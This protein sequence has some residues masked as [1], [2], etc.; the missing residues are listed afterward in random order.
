MSFSTRL[1]RGPPSV[2]PCKRGRFSDFRPLLRVFGT[3]ENRIGPGEI[4]RIKPWPRSA[5][6][7]LSDVQVPPD[8][9]RAAP[10]RQVFNEA[11]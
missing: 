5:A 8:P 2:P 1:F 9:T 10:D 6:I 3:F 7:G 11:R 4:K